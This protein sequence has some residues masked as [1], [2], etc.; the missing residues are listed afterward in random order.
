MSEQ[1]NA[2]SDILSL[3]RGLN[4]TMVDVCKAEQRSR[5][6]NSLVRQRLLPKVVRNFVMKQIKQQRAGKSRGLVEE[7]F[8]S[9]KT[10]LFKKLRDNKLVEMRLR[11]KRDQY[12]NKL[13]SMM[14][15]SVYVRMMSRLKS[16]V[17]VVRTQWKKKYLNK[18]KEYL[19]QRELDEAKELSILQEELGEFG[20]LRI[21]S[22]VPIPPE[23]RKPL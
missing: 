20:K 4:D 17:E 9:G 19:V 3:R 18:T 8:K 12:R 1:D 2:D 23:D 7:I 10:R 6:L 21:F 22:G 16:H 15:K 14:S 13:E 5:W 11:K